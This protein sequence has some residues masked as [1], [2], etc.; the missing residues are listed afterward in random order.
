MHVWH[1]LPQHPFLLLKPR[2]HVSCA[3]VGRQHPKG[4]MLA[5]SSPAEFDAASFDK[6]RLALDAVVSCF[7]VH[8]LVIRLLHNWAERR[9]LPNCNKWT[10]RWG[11]PKLGRPT[12]EDPFF[13][14]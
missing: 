2:F 12:W 11:L 4:L 7:L 14:Y 5:R 8:L 1:H 6:E 9:G 3:H 13:L 10:E